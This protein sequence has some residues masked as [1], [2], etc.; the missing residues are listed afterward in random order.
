[1]AFDS[2]KALRLSISTGRAE[3]LA[4]VP[5]LVG[6][7]NLTEDDLERMQYQQNAYKILDA[8]NLSGTNGETDSR[9]INSFK[10]QES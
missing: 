3:T 6:Q 5:A 9:G 1:V 10:Q 8:R 7:W 4:G 2:L